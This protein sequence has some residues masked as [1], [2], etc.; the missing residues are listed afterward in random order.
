MGSKRRGRAYWLK[1]KE[2]VDDGL[3]RIAAGR[4]ESALE[5]LRGATPGDEEFP[6]AVHGARK[7]LKKLRTVLRL[8]RDRIGR[9]A[10]DEQNRR[11]RDAAGRLSESRDAEV[12]LATLDALGKHFTDLPPAAFAAWREGLER[13]RDR[14]LREPTRSPSSSRSS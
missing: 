12:R 1:R 4:A 7:D 2:P 14:T 11:Y 5:R 9:E 8:L 13:D 6:D 10:Y 3:R